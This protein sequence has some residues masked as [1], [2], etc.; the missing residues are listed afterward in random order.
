MKLPARGSLVWRLYALGL[1]QLVLLAAAVAVVGYL[2]R[3]V[4]S[5]SGAGALPPPGLPLAPLLTFF[6]SGALIVGVG[7]VL[8]WRWMA[9]PLAHL[10]RAV[11]ALAGS[12]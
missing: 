10:S 2:L 6:A 7:A 11:R 5:P 8:S 4:L 1:A 9:R 3:E 12:L